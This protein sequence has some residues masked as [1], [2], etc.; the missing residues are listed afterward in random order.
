MICG[1]C[2]AWMLVQDSW[3]NLLCQDCRL[4]FD[5]LVLRQY[6]NSC[7]LACPW[8]AIYFYQQGMRQL[9]LAAKAGQSWIVYHY[10][11]QLWKKEPMLWFMADWADFIVPAPASAWSRLRGRFNLAEGMASQLAE[12]AGK[13]L[14]S[15]PFRWHWRWRKQA[16]RPGRRRRGFMSTTQLVRQNKSFDGER[17]PRLLLVDDIWTSGQTISRLMQAF[18]GCEFQ[19]AVLAYAGTQPTKKLT[20]DSESI[21][22][23]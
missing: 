2:D 6:K 21:T 22:P 18:P 8:F 19:I 23:T 9:I 15:A 11:L 20:D 5:D 1:V 12:I 3:K 4:Q 10:L 16:K 14:R 7:S 17:R 13:P